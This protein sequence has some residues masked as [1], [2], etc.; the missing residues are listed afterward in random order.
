[1]ALN[2]LPRN[3]VEAK[4]RGAARVVGVDVQRLHVRQAMLVKRALGLDIEFRRASVY[5]LTSRTFGR[6]DVTLALGLIYHCK[7]LM[8]ALDNLA[9]V[10][11]RT[12]VLETALYPPQK[13][14]APFDYVHGGQKRRIHSVGYVDN[15][16]DAQESAFNWFL[17]S[18]DS[19]GP[20]LRQ[21]GFAEVEVV[22]V[23]HERAICV[24]RK[25]DVFPDSTVLGNLKAALTLLHGDTRTVAGGEIR[26]TFDV[27]N[28]G[29]VT[30]LGTGEAGTDKG[31]VRLGAHLYGDEETEIAWDYG[32]ARL[33]SDVP[34]GGVRRLDIVL[35]AP[36]RPG[37]YRIEF[38]MVA[39]G[40]TW[41]ENLGSTVLTADLT[42]EG[43][44]QAS[45]S[46]PRGR[47]PL[48]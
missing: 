36:E 24:C 10:T 45:A 8:L 13:Q 34:P 4:R 38:D 5:D 39:E 37:S 47:D 29:L 48:G 40:V 9:Q 26:F 2:C 21:A 43:E 17:P 27:E 15:P 18:V 30:W 35:R 6:F 42:V 28:A 11:R 25:A 12:L 46:V 41:F 44:G 23:E 1:M 20:L 32:R 31:A 3:A 7:H 14:P 19:L 16:S 22:A 33:E